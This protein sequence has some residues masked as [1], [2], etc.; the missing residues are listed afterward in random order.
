MC[1]RVRRG[2]SG[3][4]FEEGEYDA[5]VQCRVVRGLRMGC[6]RGGGAGAEEKQAGG[7]G[8]QKEGGTIELILILKL[9]FF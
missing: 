6:V 1:E 2:V 4:E 3:R 7:G 9:C 5:A 8:N